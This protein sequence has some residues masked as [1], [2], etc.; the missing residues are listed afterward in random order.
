MLY[1]LIVLV[2]FAA[3]FGGVTVLF[4]AGLAV[5]A[6][7]FFNQLFAKLWRVETNQE[8]FAITALILTLLTGPG[9]IH[10]S[11]FIILLSFL[12]M[13]SKYLLVWRQKHLFNPAAVAIFLTALFGQSASWWVGNIYLVLPVLAGGIL[14]ARKIHRL[15]MVAI[16]LVTVFVLH[17]KVISNLTLYSPLLFFAFVM[18]VE[19]QTTPPN[20]KLRLI[21]AVIIGLFFNLWP[22]AALLLGNLF[23]FLVGFKQKLNLTLEEKIQLAPQIYDFVFKTDKKF[24]FLPG[25]YLE[26]TLNH[27]RRYFTIASSPT[28]EN[29]RL[30]TKFS[31][32]SSS[33]K[34]ALLNLTPGEKITA[35]NLDG[36]FI[37]PAAGNQ[38]LVFI[39]GGIGITPFRSMIKYLTD[40]NQKRD[41]ILLYCA[42]TADEF[43][44]QEIFKDTKTVY[45]VGRLEKEDLIKAA[46]DLAQRFFYL[47]GPHSMVD[48]FKKILFELGVKNNQIK[49]D[50]FP[51]YT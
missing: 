7:Y 6:C 8:S 3:V 36:D 24:S 26:W 33:F 31:Q 46:P 16:F 47:S 20:K 27:E 40:T 49:T 37:L 30:G 5:L 45:K 32:P 28:E 1:Y 23:A 51:G 2:A 12:A 34:T 18:L 38:P 35:G 44:Y 11:L 10:N 17:P 21:Y 14:I 13:L 4:S 43:I 19:P 50:Y 39:A 42:K 9:I 29:V 41:I 25:Q 22:E 48:S 15:E